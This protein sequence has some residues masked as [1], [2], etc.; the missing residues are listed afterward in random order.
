MKKV[1]VIDNNFEFIN[2]IKREFR[3]LNLDLDIDY[4]GLNEEKKYDYIV[5]N[6]INELDL[7][8]D[9]YIGDYY[10]LNMDMEFNNILFEGNLITYGLGNKN[11]I[12]VSSISEDKSGFV[13]C[14]QRYIKEDVIPQEIPVNRKFKDNYELYA[15]MICITIA[16]IEGIAENKIRTNLE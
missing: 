15:F 9:N 11:T 8:M 7:C 5:I 13:Y 16:L 10:L 1:F 2:Y 14:I 6:N 4:K 3:M 12:T